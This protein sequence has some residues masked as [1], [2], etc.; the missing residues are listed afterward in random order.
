MKQ[1]K[2]EIQIKTKEYIVKIFYPNK[3]IRVN[4][5]PKI[6]FVQIKPK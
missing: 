5:H 2:K 6:T 4:Q 1:F 3:I